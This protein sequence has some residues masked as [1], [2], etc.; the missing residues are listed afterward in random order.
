MRGLTRLDS[1]S[2]LLTTAQYIRIQPHLPYS[3]LA[4]PVLALH[5]LMMYASGGNLD[6]LLLSR[7][8][9]TGFATGLSANDVADAE[10]IEK[11][12]KEERIKAF[13]RRRQT[14]KTERENR[15]AG[16]SRLQRPFIGGMG[17]FRAE[18]RGILL[19]S[20]EEIAQ[21][22]GDIT[23]GLSFLVS[24]LLY[25]CSRLTDGKIT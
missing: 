21:L 13:K 11:L 4:P 12:P 3:S 16:I 19:L 6:S 2:K 5:V 7:S 1:L 20:F 22:F 9:S 17:A 15:C 14:A 8:H 24:D 23:E 18:N 10:S 25:T